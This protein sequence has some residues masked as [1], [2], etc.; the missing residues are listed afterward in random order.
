MDGT[1]AR[2]A[3]EIANGL[4]DLGACDDIA[5]LRKLAAPPAKLASRVTEIEHEI[6]RGD[7]LVRAARYRDAEAVLVTAREQADAVGYAATRSRAELVL[8]FLHSQQ[9]RHRDS[10]PLLDAALNHALEAN[11]DFAVARSYVELVGAALLVGD[12]AHARD[13][14]PTAD[15]MVR[16]VGDPALERARLIRLEVLVPTTMGDYATG[17]ARATEAIPKLEAMHD[18]TGAAKLYRVQAALLTGFGRFDDARKAHDH[19]I[20]LDRDLYGVTHPI[21]AEALISRATLLR[22]RGAYAD[23]EADLTAGY[24]TLL[25]R[26]GPDDLSTIDAGNDLAKIDVLFGRY[27]AAI[28]RLRPAADVLERKSSPTLAGNARRDLAEALRVAGH[29][30]DADRELGRTVEINSKLAGLAPILDKLEL[31]RLRY[32]QGRYVEARTIAVRVEP[33]L[34]KQF[35]ADSPLL[36]DLWILNA[37]LDVAQG[38]PR[39]AIATLAKVVSG[40]SLAESKVVLADALT[41]LG[42]HAG[43]RAARDEATKHL[44]KIGPTARPDLRGEL[45]G[46]RQ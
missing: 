33:E 21:Y 36:A 37:R 1:T 22:E 17:L 28:A 18:L 46:L 5:S 8:A 20:D 41:R 10:K 9:K 32:A 24:Q 26:L 45:A 35:G 13:L 2:Y 31:A 40:Q 12:T 4:P 30:E 7:M 23:A 29:L 34:V 27:D 39:E 25:A 3:L 42:N 6:S 16:R 38:H 19:E 14:L 43:A 44:D 11:D 15:A